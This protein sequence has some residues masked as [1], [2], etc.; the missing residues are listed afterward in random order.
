MSSFVFIFWCNFLHI[1]SKSVFWFPLGQ[2]L[3]WRSFFSHSPYSIQ[4]ICNSENFSAGIETILQDVSVVSARIYRIGMLKILILLNKPVTDWVHLWLSCLVVLEQCICYYSLLLQDKQDCGLTVVSP[5]QIYRVWGE[6]QEGVYK[7]QR[8]EIGM[9]KSKDALLVAK[10]IHLLMLM[11][12]FKSWNGY[13][14]LF[15]QVWL[16]LLN[17]LTPIEIRKSSSY[18]KWTM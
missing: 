1:H 3:K 14:S 2:M 8:K 6:M 12:S 10:W 13:C 15:S 7:K 9:R 5:L 16:F 18:D 11:V 17:L 4:L